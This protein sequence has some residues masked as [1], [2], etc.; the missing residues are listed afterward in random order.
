MHLPPDSRFPFQRRDTDGAAGLQRD[1]NS[2]RDQTVNDRAEQFP[3]MLPTPSPISRRGGLQIPP[4]REQRRAGCSRRA[5]ASQSPGCHVGSSFNERGGRGGLPSGGLLRHPALWGDFLPRARRGAA[6][7]PSPARPLCPP[8]S[9]GILLGTP[10]F[11][12]V[13]HYTKSREIKV[14]RVLWESLLVTSL[15]ITGFLSE[16]SK[17]E[18][19]LA[20][21][22]L[23]ARAS[24]SQLCVPH[25]LLGLCAHL[26][27]KRIINISEEHY[28]SSF[29]NTCTA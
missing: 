21:R 9:P 8:V 22:R 26:H 7:S 1:P 19:S 17:R 6:A 23:G 3:A 25:R 24:G 27:K 5:D 15:G 16:V 13:S 11:C 2:Y 28:T 4:S 29:I 10:V 20:V 14:S 18:K 12:W